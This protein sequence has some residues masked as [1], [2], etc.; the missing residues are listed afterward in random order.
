MGGFPKPDAAAVVGGCSVVL[1]CLPDSRIVGQVVHSLEAVLRAGQ[2]FLDMTTGD[3]QDSAAL[4]GWLNERGVGLV[5][6]PV[7]GSSDQLRRQE[8]LVLLSGRSEDVARGRQVLGALGCPL[9]EMPEGHHAVCLKLVVNL[10]L[11]LNRAALAEGLA[12]AEACGLPLKDVLSVLQHSPASSRIMDSKGPKMLARDYSP[13]AHLAQHLKDVRLIRELA[14]RRGA[15]V[16]LTQTH[17]RLLEQ[18]VERGWGQADNSA[19]VEVYRAALVQGRPD[20]QPA[21]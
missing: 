3:P 15:S 10:V 21:S 4:A 1:L 19:L 5:E 8:A 11:G 13:Q 18:A 20:E 16:P 7:I 17:Q 6:A 14:A 9:R 12:L 2:V